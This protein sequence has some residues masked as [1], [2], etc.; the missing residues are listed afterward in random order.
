MSRGWKNLEDRKSLDCLQETVNGNVDVNNSA[1]AGSEGIEEN[2]R[3]NMHY[4]SKHL[5]Q[6]E[7]TIRRTR[8]LT[9]PP[10]GYRWK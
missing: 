3:E 6:Y 5:N 7:Q 9:P 10:E 4:F 8:T 1:S 2:S